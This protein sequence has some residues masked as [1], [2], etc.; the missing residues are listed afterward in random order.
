[1]SLKTINSVKEEYLTLVI[2]ENTL[3][4]KKFWLNNFIWTLPKQESTL[5]GEL[6][7]NHVNICLR[8]WFDRYENANTFNLARQVLLGFIKW[9]NEETH[10]NIKIKKSNVLGRRVTCNLTRSPYSDKEIKH[11]I[12]VVKKLKNRK[13]ELLL[14][15]LL[16]IAPRASEIAKIK[17]KDVFSKENYMTLNRKGGGIQEVPICSILNQ[18]LI[19]YYKELN[20]PSLDSYIFSTDTK[21]KPN[22]FDIYYL[23]KSIAQEAGI[24]YRGVHLFRNNLANVFDN[25]KVPDSIFLNNFGWKDERMKKIYVK[26]QKDN[27]HRKI[28]AKVIKSLNILEGK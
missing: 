3:K 4:A 1:M 23:M 28:Q 22:R 14:M 25:L 19:L 24:K 9:G 16:I 21:S 5:V 18:L 2:S 8:N 17:W 15:I 10:F 12:M 7:I 27:K 20:R 26:N 13:Y 11:L 6:A